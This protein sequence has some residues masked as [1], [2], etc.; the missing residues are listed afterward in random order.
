MGGTSKE[1]PKGNGRGRVLSE[2]WFRLKSWSR[3]QQCG[4]ECLDA[5]FLE[6]CLSSRCHLHIANDD[7]V[8][9][10]LVGQEIAADLHDSAIPI[11][12]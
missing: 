7:P 11:E 12:V 2:C 9:S 10:R 3:C 1:T 5:C 6:I 4:E 8:V